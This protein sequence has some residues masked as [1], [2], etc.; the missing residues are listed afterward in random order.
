MLI[1]TSMVNDCN[2]Q[3]PKIFDE[4]EAPEVSDVTI[5]QVEQ[6]MHNWHLRINHAHPADIRT[7]IL[8]HGHPDGKAVH[9]VKL[10]CTR[11]HTGKIERAAYRNSSHMRTV[12]IVL[13]MDVIGPLHPAGFNR[14]NI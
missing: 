12:G 4:H 11:C 7:E 2:I 9:R 6:K 14:E 13:C 10:T 8:R 5:T 1:V 3:A